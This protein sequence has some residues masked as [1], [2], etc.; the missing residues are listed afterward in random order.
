ME[1]KFDMN[2][3]PVEMKMNTPKVEV[4]KN[5]GNNINFE[6]EKESERQSSCVYSCNDNDSHSSLLSVLRLHKR[7]FLFLGFP[8]TQNRSFYIRQ[9]SYVLDGFNRSARGNQSCRIEYD[10]IFPFEFCNAFFELY[11]SVFLL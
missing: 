11:R 10:K 7:K 3:T 9:L 1:I 2:V 8:K 6:Q 4:V 5:D